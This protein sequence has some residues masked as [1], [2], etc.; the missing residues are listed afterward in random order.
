M[1]TASTCRSWTNKADLETR[2]MRLSI[3][4]DTI[5]IKH[6][7]IPFPSSLIESFAQNFRNPYK[8]ILKVY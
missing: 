7:L 8:F 4:N 2:D 1:A 6:C 3:Q 5:H